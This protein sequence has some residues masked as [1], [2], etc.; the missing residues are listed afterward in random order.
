MRSPHRTAR[1]AAAATAAALS[2]LVAGCS[3]G[4]SNSVDA[5]RVGQRIVEV[6]RG[7]VEE[8]KE[9]AGEQT[10]RVE[11]A[12]PG[13][14]AREGVVIRSDTRTEFDY[15]TFQ[16]TLRTVLGSLEDYWGET[17]PDEFGVR[18]TP[19]QGG[20]TYYRPEEEPGPSCGGEP[21]PA[22][23]AFYCSRGDFIAW[24][25]TGLIIPYYVQA[26]DF[27][28]AFVLAHEFGHAVQVRLPRQERLGIL[29]ELQADCFAGAWSRSAADQRLLEAGDLDEATVAV[30]SARDVPGT[31]WTEPQAHGTGFQRIRAFGDGYEGGPTACYPA[32]AEKW[33]L[34]GAAVQPTGPATP[35]AV[36]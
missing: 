21:A 16:T 28:A 10:G 31:P 24:D 17:L 19:L 9:R 29:R 7:A 14:A 13:Q 1:T 20:Y 5:D 33:I 8:A 2:L 26:G 30:I 22:R 34:P 35:G 11:R 18:F 4:E 36:G 25:E 6:V 3:T 27:A 23:N 32:P 12:E 15:P